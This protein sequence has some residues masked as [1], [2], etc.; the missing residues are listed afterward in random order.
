MKRTSAL[1]GIIGIIFLLFATFGYVLTAG[2]FARLFSG[3]NLLAGIIAVAGWLV[4]SRGS[5]GTMAGARSTRYGTN[6]AVYSLAF[7]GVLVAVNYLSGRYHRQFDLTAQNA[8]SLSPQSITVLK[9]LKQPVKLYGFVEGG[10]SVVLQA[11]YQEYAYQ[12]PLITH[13]LVDPT[14]HPEL[15]ERYKVS[16]MNT[17]HIQYG[18]EGGS[19]TNVS[20][21]TEQAITNGIVKVTKTSEKTV[22]YLTGEGED[23]PDDANGATGMGQF[24]EALQGESY[25]IDKVNLVTEAKVPE[26]CAVMVV[27]GPTRPLVPHVIDAFNDYLKGGGRALV[28][29]KPPQP[30]QSVDETALVKFASDWGVKAGHNLVVDQVVRLEAGPALGLDPVVN[31]YAPHPITASFDKQTVFPMVRTVDPVDPPIPGL[32]VT[33]LA[34]TSET[35]WAETDIDG[36]FKRQTAKFGGNDVKG[37][38]VVADA[39]DA[40]LDLLKYGK[41]EARLVVLGDTDI[42]NNQFLGNFFNRDFIM[43]CVDWLAGES[44]SITIRPRGLRASRFNLTVEEFDVVFVLSVL[45]LPELLLIIGFAVWWERRN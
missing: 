27:A 33:A 25:K 38:V 14:R 4:S 37:P 41:G 1:S 12:S 28:M 11:L 16:V 22:C 36:I 15:A 32:E 6:A 7:I 24:K 5:I 20:D 9:E 3:V 44:N 26:D 2:G 10:R 42:A 35:S 8:F 19:G 13:Q 39:I 23:D 21:T 34:K 18:G 29:L 45:L 31:T 17:T 43:N 40:N 30:G